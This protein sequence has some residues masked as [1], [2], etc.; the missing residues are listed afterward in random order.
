MI[1]VFGCDFGSLILE[2]HAAMG[3]NPADLVTILRMVSMGEAPWS[4]HSPNS[5]I[6]DPYGFV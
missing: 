4:S 2:N 3:R 1:M 6:L 5:I